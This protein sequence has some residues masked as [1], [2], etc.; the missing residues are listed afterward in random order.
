MAGLSIVCNSHWFLQ[1]HEEL[2]DNMYKSCKRQH[3]TYYPAQMVK[4]TLRVVHVTSCYHRTVIHVLF[5]VNAVAGR[6]IWN[7]YTAPWWQ[8][9][10]RRLDT[11]EKFQVGNPFSVHV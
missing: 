9:L 10:C 5:L 2:T 3:W 6:V 1:N 8:L 4:E 7:G 11:T